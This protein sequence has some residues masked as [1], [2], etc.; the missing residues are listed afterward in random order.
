[1]DSF[2]LSL[3]LQDIPYILEAIG[4]CPFM[5]NSQGSLGYRVMKLK[6]LFQIC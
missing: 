5:I 6:Q 4:N 1:M 3:A 2:F